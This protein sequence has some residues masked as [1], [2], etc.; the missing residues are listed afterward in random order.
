MRC[1]RWECT[2][3]GLSLL[4][5]ILTFVEVA[6]LWSETLTPW[7]VLFSNIIKI[8]CA[9]AILALD[10]VVYLQ[11]T[12]GHYSTIGLALDSIFM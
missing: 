11:R 8:V 9:F 3:T 5:V 1:P 6:R 12:D 2:N 4:S 7:T 10:I